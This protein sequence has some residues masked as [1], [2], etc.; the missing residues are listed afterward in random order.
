[1]RHT[2]ELDAFERQH[3]GQFWFQPRQPQEAR[4]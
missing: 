3:A 2:D 4:A 1:M